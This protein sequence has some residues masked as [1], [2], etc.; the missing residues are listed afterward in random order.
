M[1]FFESFL[2]PESVFIYGRLIACEDL[3]LS[4]YFC[5]LYKPRNPNGTG[6]YSI[7]SEHYETFLEIYDSRFREKYGY[8]RPVI[9]E[10]VGKYLDCGILSKG[11]ARV[12]CTG[13]SEEYLVAFTCKMRYFCPSCH[14]KRLLILGEFLKECVLLPADY[15]QIVFSIP[16]MLR[17]YFIFNRKLLGK[18]SQCGYTSIKE[19]Y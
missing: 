7:L 1:V 2:R 16:K 17:K 13:C 9:S 11:F 4:I 3:R 6:F 19:A 15:R 5:K 18:L 12:K 14:Q 10:A 8:Y